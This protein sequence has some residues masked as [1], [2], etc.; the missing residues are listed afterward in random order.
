MAY[1]FSP[2]T[3]SLLKDC[4][5]CFWLAFR[6]GV[7]Q[8]AGIFPSLPGGMD[9]VLKKYF[10]GFRGH[11][12]PPELSSLK[13]VELF[14]DSD[15]LSEWRNNWKGIQWTDKKGNIFRGAVDDILQKGSKLIV[16]DF[17][18]R[19]AAVKEETPGYY[20]DQMDIYNLLFRKNGIQT[21]DY[22]YLLFYYPDKVGKD[23]NVHFNTELIKLK[24]DVKNA[25]KIFKEAVKVLEGPEPPASEECEYCAYCA[26]K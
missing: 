6:K 3:L 17:K 4:P 25:E 7:K 16:L 9:R 2:S 1:K 11:G 20:Q 24:T 5:R 12:L 14:A 21:E 10:D 19:G 8:P 15:K 23:S 26:Q 13:G 22:A 18:T